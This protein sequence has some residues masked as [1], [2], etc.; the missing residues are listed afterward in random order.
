MQLRSLKVFCDVVG[1]RSFS[2]AA[3]ENGISQ[4]GASQVVHQLETSLGAKL[5]DRSKRP[6]VLT[7]AGE[8]YYAGCRRIVERYL[9]LEDEIRTMNQEPA[10]R[11][12]VASIYSVGLHYMNQCLKRFMTQWP[13]VNVRLEY[14]HPN[15]VCD[16]VEHDQA[17][18]GLI[19]YPKASRTITALPWRKEPML[20]VCHPQHRLAS[21]GVRS[22][23]DLDGEKMIG[24]DAS[25][26]IRREIDRV[27]DQHGVEVDVTMEF[28]NIEAIKRAVEIDA[29]IALLPE[30]TVAREVQAGSLAAVR[31]PTDELQR[32]I[33]I[34]HRRGKELGKA[35]RRFIE[36]LQDDPAK[37]TCLAADFAAANDTAANESANSDLTAESVAAAIAG[38]SGDGLFAGAAGTASG[39]NA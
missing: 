19:S 15:R 14:Q 26:T 13:K 21:A 23:A 22:L 6:F 4:S 3:E 7:P 20:L 32:P 33:G 24:F 8:T 10:G 27:L 39:L 28:D 16:M 25:L 37:N 11:L 35:A 17:D 2:R 9:A 1:Y 12:R 31:L 38:E 30:P 18:V 34:I 36:L 29:G 5:I